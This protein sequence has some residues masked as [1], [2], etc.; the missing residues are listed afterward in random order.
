MEIFDVIKRVRRVL[1]EYILSE[2]NR[3]DYEEAVELKID[4]DN[5]SFSESFG[6]GAWC[7]EDFDERDIQ[8]AFN[9]VATPL[10]YFAKT[11]WATKCGACPPEATLI[12]TRKGEAIFIVL[13]WN[14]PEENLLQTQ[15][16]NDSPTVIVDS[17]IKQYAEA[18]EKFLH[19]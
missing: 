11:Y 12:I 19:E 7:M 9:L 1:K 14:A 8:H 2:L 5:C 18:K 6:P 10:Q 16:V 15:E 4:P 13:N 17:I 3:N